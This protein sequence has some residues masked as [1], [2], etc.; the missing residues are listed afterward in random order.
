MVRKLVEGII[1]VS[2]IISPYTFLP[3]IQLWVTPSA[4]RNSYRVAIPY[5]IY[6]QGS[7]LR[8]QPWAV[9][10]SPS[11]ALPKGGLGRG[12]FPH[13]IPWGGLEWGLR[14]VGEGLEAYLMVLMLH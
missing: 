5:Y 1:R 4:N 14:M 12:L 6:T 7:V 10:V 13:H 2:I 3:T 11:P 9:S 8:P